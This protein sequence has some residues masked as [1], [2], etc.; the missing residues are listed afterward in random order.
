M[1]DQELEVKF[2]VR[3]LAVVEARLTHL[4]AKLVQPHTHEFNLR[5]DTPDHKL[6]LSFQVLRLRQDTIDFQRSFTNPRRRTH[7]PR[8]RIYGR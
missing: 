1:P 8:N 3:E 6:A 2:Y 5:F 7:P 4:G